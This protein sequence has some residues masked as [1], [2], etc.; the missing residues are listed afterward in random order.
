[1][2]KLVPKFQFLTILCCFL[3]V[4][5]IN[6]QIEDFKVGNTTRQMLVYAPSTIVPGRPLL[7]SMHGYNQDINYQKNQT[8][9]ETI[10][11]ENNF[12]VI[13]FWEEIGRLSSFQG[14]MVSSNFRLLSYS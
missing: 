3:L 12:V 5:N 13:S 4:N 7:I 11:K 6:A 9:W 2:R 8:Q 10:A 14:R 1:M